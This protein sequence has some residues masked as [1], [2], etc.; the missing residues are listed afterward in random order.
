MN[1]LYCT[2]HVRLEAQSSSLSFAQG[3]GSCSDVSGV[4]GRHPTA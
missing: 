1:D 2:I 4:A 3:R